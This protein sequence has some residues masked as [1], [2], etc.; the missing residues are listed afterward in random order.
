M[1][2]RPTI[3]KEELSVLPV[4]AF[5]G[6]IITI[7]RNEQVD[8]A[9]EYLKSQSLIGFDTETKPNFSRHSHNH[10]ALIQLS[11]QD[12]CYLFRL[13]MIG[14][15]TALIDLLN[16]THVTKIGLSLRDDFIAIKKRA[17]INKA[18]FI[19]LQDFAKNYNIEETSLTKLFAI[20]FGQRISKNKRLSNWEAQ[21][22]NEAQ[23]LYAATD[24]WACYKIYTYLTQEY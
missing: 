21:P 8:D 2:F 9:I 16:D 3:S 18:S 14:M 11:S 23:Q 17:T 10:V 12:I 7:D 22:L 6:K 5:Q 24:A 19:D 20:I 13:N 4:A 1:N 15:P